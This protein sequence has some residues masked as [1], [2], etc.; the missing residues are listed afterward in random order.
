MGYYMRFVSTDNRSLLLPELLEVLLADDPDYAFK[1]DEPS[2]RISGILIH[3]GRAVAELEVNVPGDGLFDEERDELVEA[4]AAG[5]GAGK[6]RILEALR[7]ATWLLAIR[8]LS[9]DQ[10]TEDV[11]ALLDPVWNWLHLNRDGI[12]NADGEGF[13]EGRDLVL[14]C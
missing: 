6:P 14:E 3:S 2:H 1:Y 13:Y 8:V 11:L 4:A 10:D 7:S 5:D 12:V 9:G